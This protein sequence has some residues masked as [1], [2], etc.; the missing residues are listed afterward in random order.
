M[1]RQ[2]VEKHLCVSDIQTLS[3]SYT[4]KTFFTSD[5]QNIKQSV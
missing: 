1:H 5:W 4:N 2:F 3:F